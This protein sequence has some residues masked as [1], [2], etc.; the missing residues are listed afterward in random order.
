MNCLVG[1]LSGSRFGREA[2]AATQPSIEG[3]IDFAF[4]M[5]CV[6][7][8]L[9]ERASLR[10]VGFFLCSTIEYMRGPEFK[11]PAGFFRERPVEQRF[12]LASQVLPR[13]RV[14]DCLPPLSAHDSRE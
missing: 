7:A 14:Y 8:G 5:N 11:R 1:R 6:H 3:R 4:N 9:A 2:D 12:L 10:E 13:L